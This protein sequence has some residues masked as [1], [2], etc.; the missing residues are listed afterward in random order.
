MTPGGRFDE[1]AGVQG[2]D[3]AFATPVYAMR[4]DRGNLF[5]VGVFATAGPTDGR[6][7]G[8][9]GAAGGGGRRA[10]RR[11][12]AP[13]LA[14]AGAAAQLA[15]G[16]DLGD[17]GGQF[18]LRLGVVD[19]G[20]AIGE[21]LLGLALG[22]FR[23][24]L[25]EVGGADGGVRQHRHAVRL[26]LEDAAGHEDE[27]LLARAGLLDPDRTGADPG[28]QRGVLGIDAQLARLARQRD[29]LGLALEDRGLGADDVDVNHVY[30]RSEER[31]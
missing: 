5:F 11:S 8:W 23:L 27:L 16:G 12:W 4:V 26:D 1:T 28:D 22:L 20:G 9:R 31:R 24:G 14:A 18:G 10:C 15:D 29:E 25:V 19:V 17:R 13:V 21:R 2:T 7:P 3:D 6:W 30:H